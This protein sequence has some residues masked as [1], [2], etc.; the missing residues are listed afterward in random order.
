M[1]HLS[2]DSSEHHEYPSSRWRRKV[3]CDENAMELIEV[4]DS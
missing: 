3:G 4:R 1:I 2:H